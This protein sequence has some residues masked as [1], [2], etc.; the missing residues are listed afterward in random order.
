MDFGKGRELALEIWF[1]NQPGN[2]FPKSA[3]R[4]VL[5]AVWKTPAFKIKASSGKFV[6][7]WWL[8]G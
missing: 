8:Q 3:N 4:T 2:E 1:S 5:T 7:N 6:G